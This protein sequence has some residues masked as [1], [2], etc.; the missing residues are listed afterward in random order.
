MRQREKKDISDFKII[1]VS[2][3]LNKRDEGV[4]SL[5][6]MGR[7]FEDYEQFANTFAFAIMCPEMFSSQVDPAK[8][9]ECLKTEDM[10]EKMK[11]FDADYAP[12]VRFRDAS[13]EERSFDM[14]PR[15]FYP[16][17]EEFGYEPPESGPSSSSSAAATGPKPPSNQ[18]GSEGGPSALSSGIRSLNLGSSSYQ[19]FSD[20]RVAHT[21]RSSSNF[22]RTYFICVF[23]IILMLAMKQVLEF[24][25]E[26][27]SSHRKLLQ[28]DEI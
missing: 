18:K 28:H 10:L 21:R 6:W 1:D 19:K 7:V 25:C 16:L 26:R 22:Q 9:K 2:N 13:A 24:L 17:Y 5:E 23:A 11:S 12:A 20:E 3:A 8:I 27:K 15:T 14:I 4:D